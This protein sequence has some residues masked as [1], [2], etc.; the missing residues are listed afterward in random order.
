V[1]KPGFID[2]TSK[3]LLVTGNQKY[4]SHYRERLLLTFPLTR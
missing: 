4:G 2:F 3:K 1:F